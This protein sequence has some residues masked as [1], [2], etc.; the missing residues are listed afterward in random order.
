MLTV[1]AIVM[2]STT[3]G[4]TK[5]RFIRGASDHALNYWG[6]Q[7]PNFDYRYQ[8]FNLKVP[9]SQNY[10]GR[11]R[12]PPGPPGITALYLFHELLALDLQ[13]FSESFIER[14]FKKLAEMLIE[15]LQKLCYF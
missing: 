12:G 14:N 1:L 6:G 15:H 10:W 9:C 13:L 4:R 5:V 8:I 11:G 3:Q 2:V 7:N